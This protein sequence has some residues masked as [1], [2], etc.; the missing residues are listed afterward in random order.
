MKKKYKIGFVILALIL[1]LVF[2]IYVC[3]NLVNNNDSKK[4]QKLDSIPKYGYSLDKRATK[5]MKEEFKELK[6]ILNSDEINYEEYAKE[7]SKLFV[8][9]LFT[10]NNKI[11]KYD[12]PCLEYILED[13]TDNF[14]NNV[15]DTLY[16]YIVDNSNSDRKQELPEVNSI[17]VESVDTMK[18]SY[19]D[20]EYNGYKVNLNW[21]YKKNLGYDNSGIIRL[22][23]KDNKL[24]VV[25][26]E[27]SEVGDEENN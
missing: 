12:T 20:E 1:I 17:M 7:L 16:K 22:I 23:K 2:L 10:L 6:T 26:Y 8:I 18:Y 5:L 4:V 13:N 3:L 27:T 14:V 19:K 11:N 21:T 15:S 9:D 25:G 24:Y